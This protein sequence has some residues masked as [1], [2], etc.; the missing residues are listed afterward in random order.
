MVTGKTTSGFSFSIPRKVMDNMEFVD[1]LAEASESN[2]IAVSKTVQLLLGDDVRKALY[3]H[4]R[5]E[6]GR[7]PVKAVC[8]EVVEIIKAF[9]QEGKN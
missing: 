7:V 3:N 8:E 2:P 9:G 6:D 4:V 5:T 1:T